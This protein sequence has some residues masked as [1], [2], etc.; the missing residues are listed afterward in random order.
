MSEQK[1]PKDAQF[2]KF[3][4]LDEEWRNT[5]MSK[6]EA[7]V[8]KEIRTVVSNMVALEAAKALDE[9]LISLKEQVATA[10]AIYKEGKKEQLIKLEFLIECLK[11]RGANITD[12]ESFVQKSKKT[13]ITAKKDF[14]GDV[15]AATESIIQDAL[16]EMK[17]G[18]SKDTTVTFS[19]PDGESV[20]FQGDGD[21]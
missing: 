1:D 16:K 9:D 21:S 6:S 15:K 11:S 12:V 20:S 17:K 18:I 4:K 10:E 5:Q 13:K 19:T 2:K 14:T 3:K 7:D 8:D